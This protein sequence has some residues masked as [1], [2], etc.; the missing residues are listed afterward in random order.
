MGADQG[1]PQ[2]PGKFLCYR[3][4]LSLVTFPEPP[5][6]YGGHSYKISVAR[7]HEHIERA[8]QRP[9]KKAIP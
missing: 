7:K 9:Q 5:A 1:E 3:A 4:D 2:G 8:L 6:G